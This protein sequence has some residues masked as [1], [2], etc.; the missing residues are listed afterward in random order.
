MGLKKEAEM[1]WVGDVVVAEPVVEVWVL[2]NWARK[3]V[4]GKM[5]RDR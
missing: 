2:G 4:G 1:R 3:G 5:E